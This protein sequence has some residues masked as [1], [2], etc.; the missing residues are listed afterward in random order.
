MRFSQADNSKNLSIGTLPIIFVVHSM[1]GLVVKKA[2]LLGQNDTQYQDM[3]RSVSAIVFL[4]TPHR[5]TNLA[6]ILNRVL[7]VSFQSPKNFITDLNKNSSALEE[8][9]EQFRHVAPRLSI[10][11]FY[12]T[13]ATPVGPTRLQVLEKDSSILGYPKEISKALNAD[14]HD[15]CKYSDPEDP[16]YISVRN[17]LRSLVGRL[18]PKGADVASSQTL[19]EA[20]LIERLLGV[21]SEPEED[22]NSFRRWWIPGTC[23]WILREPIIRSWLDESLESRVVWFNASPA[24]GKSIL[25]TQIINHFRNTNYL[26]QYYFFKFS[27]QTK[28]SPTAMLR[29]LASQIAKHVPIYRRNLLEL[30][31]GGHRLEKADSAL[32]WQRLFESVLFKIETSRPLYWVIDALDE[33]ESPRVLLDLLRTVAASQTK[34]RILFLSRKTEPLAIA[35]DRLSG[36]LPVHLLEKRAHDFN[37]HDIRT[38]VNED[39]KHMRGSEELKEQVVS[40]I[41]TRASGNF[42]WVRLVLEEILSCHTEEAIQETLDEIPSDM[43]E[44]YQR[45]EQTIVNSSKKGDVSLARTLFQWTIC[46]QRSLT[47]KE[48]SEALRPEFP[49]FLDL[50]R[51]IRDVC[52]QFIQVSQAGQVGMVHQTARDYLLQTANDELCI[53]PKRTHEKLFMKTVST[54]LDIRLGSKPTQN[55]HVEH[56]LYYAATSWTF[57]LRQSGTASDEALDV[58]I[59][60]FRSPKVLNWIYLLA[61]SGRMEILVK[62]AKVLSH[63]VSVTRRINASRNPLLHRLSDLELLDKWI[64]DLPKVVGKFSKY[65]LSEPSAIYKLVPPFC[66]K[67]SIL[68]Q[69]FHKAGPETV[70]IS[71]ISNTVW[72]DNLARIALPQGNQAWK[73][74]CAGQHVAVLSSAGVIVI[75]NSYNFAKVCTLQH[76]EPVTAIC[77]DS[78]GNQLVSCGLYNTML[79]SI[80]SG[81]LISSTTTPADSRA[82]TIG[83]NEND[84]KIIVGSNDKTLR[85]LHTNDLGAGWHASSLDRLREASEIEGAVANSPMCM[86]LNGDATQLGVSYRGFPLS[87]WALDEARCIG[88]CRRVKG[89]LDR[90][91]NSSTSWFAVDRFT[92]NPVSGHVIGIYRDGCLFKWHPVTDEAQEVQSAADEVAASPDGKLFVTSNSNGTVRVWSFTYFSVIY[93]LSSS[94]L[95][96]GLAFS[97]DGKRFYDLRGSSINAWEPNSLVRFAETEESSSDTASEDHSSTLISQ[98]S[99]AW[100]EQYEAI[101]SLCIAPIDDWYCVGNEEGAVDL[102]NSR[103]GETT[104]FARLL[105]FLSITHIAWSDDAEHIAA[106]VLGGKIVLKR[107]E[108]KGHGNIKGAINLKPMPSPKIDLEGRGI[109]QILFSRNSRLLLIVTED[110]GQVVGVSD[111]TIRASMKLENARA[112]RWILH[113]TQDQSLLAFGTDDVKI[114]H[115]DDLSVQCSLVYHEGRPRFDSRTSFY[116]GDDQALGLMPLTVNQEGTCHA[117]SSVNKAMLTQ[118]GEHVL[119][120]IHDSCGQGGMINRV[121]IFTNSAFELNTE[122]DTATTLT[123]LYIPPTTMSKVEI[124]LG[125]LAG[126]RLVY[127]DQDLWVYTFKLGARYHEEA[128]KRHYFIPRDWVSTEGLALCS[129]M[130]DGT[131]LCPKHDQ[132]AVIRSC[133]NVNDF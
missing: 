95:V 54:I 123:Y 9:N 8:L 32:I 70:S 130:G 106:A 51:T 115:W 91:P 48:L 88:R 76:L 99:E 124:A 42:L 12:E 2:Y 94:D 36:R 78:K 58:L 29:S 128:P 24:S 118:D 39:I 52:G 26:C 72:D 6:E 126:S 20:N 55:Q 1:G 5:G 101:S 4:A 108:P 98:A 43:N 110:R 132:V 61:I 96:T 35:F 66:P 65:L 71:G 85:F 89:S 44:L 93:Q 34:I 79:W 21:S 16:N 84:T 113:P 109:H 57:H 90:Q 87:V 116:A 111:A 53:K 125:I 49:A 92:W 38:L 22:F 100:L 63:F 14:H 27:D 67:S 3:V 41:M 31:L 81:H 131:L 11:S 37:S 60:L 25:A 64:I 112:R 133:L 33:A 40:K 59:K 15:V 104:E 82:M 28:R 47:L 62:A 77:F 74:G 23:D 97:P 45:M 30:S 102:I 114:L 122:G 83:F 80:P 17:A 127:L 7:T 105:N 69:Q 129:M 121:L 86:A 56:F 46:A 120:E 73:I 75:W 119:V 50:E 107:L 18:R 19:E 10:V 117:D 13:L 68:Y 103:T